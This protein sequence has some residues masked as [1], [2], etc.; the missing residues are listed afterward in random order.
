MFKIFDMNSFFIF[1]RFVIVNDFFKFD[2]INK[3]YL[4]EFIYFFKY[5]LFQNYD[6]F[7]D[8]FKDKI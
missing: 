2:D 1:R 7:H 6:H 8:D 4:K 5:K 3:D